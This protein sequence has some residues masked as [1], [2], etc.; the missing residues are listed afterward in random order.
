MR[1]WSPNYKRA[2]MVVR[3]LI[4]TPETGRGSLR[5]SRQLVILTWLV[6]SRLRRDCLKNQ[7]QRLLRAIPKVSSDFLCELKLREGAMPTKGVLQRLMRKPSDYWAVGVL[8]DQ[9][10]V[11]VGHLRLLWIALCCSSCVYE[12]HPFRIYEY[13]P[14]FQQLW[15]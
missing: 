15:S 13:T 14:S 4:P 8:W 3:T 2:C 10:Q 11:I 1:P 6:E 5:L 9:I 7:G 12:M